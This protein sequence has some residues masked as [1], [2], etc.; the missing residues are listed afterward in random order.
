MSLKFI[1]NTCT[2]DLKSC[3]LSENLISI[4]FLKI[5]HTN[6]DFLMKNEQ[7]HKKLS[8]VS[9]KVLNVYTKITGQT[10][11]WK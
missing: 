3:V 2:F 5:I 1:E 8:K 6:F 9:F 11:I 10:E 4:I 7:K